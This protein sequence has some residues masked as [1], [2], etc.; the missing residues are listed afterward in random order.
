[1]SAHFLMPLVPVIFFII[2]TCCFFVRTACILPGNSDSGE[3]LSFEPI[4]C[5]FVHIDVSRG[6]RQLCYMLLRG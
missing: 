5:M 1:M 6:V 4:I 3:G 2:I